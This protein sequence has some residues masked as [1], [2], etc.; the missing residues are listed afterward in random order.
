MAGVVAIVVVLVVACALAYERV[1]LR[2]I[3]CLHL[4]E[5]AVAV[6]R[7]KD[8][9]RQ[10]WNV[11]EF[12]AAVPEMTCNNVGW[13]GVG[14]DGVEVTWECTI[15]D[16]VPA[17][18]AGGTVKCEGWDYPDDPFVVAGSCR[19][20]YTLKPFPAPAPPARAAGLIGT[21]GYWIDN[22][23]Q[24]L[25]CGLAFV[26]LA[27]V[28][29]LTFPAALLYVIGSSLVVT[30]RDI[31]PDYWI[32]TLVVQ[33]LAGSLVLVLAGVF[34]LIIS[35]VSLY[36]EPA[37]MQRAGRVFM[38]TMDRAGASASALPAAEAEPEEKWEWQPSPRPR[39][40]SPPPTA[41]GAVQSARAALAA[42]ARPCKRQ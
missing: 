27:W 7:S 10:L 2:D 30:L 3:T 16:D 21:L 11:G 38:D 13:D 20:L 39:S 32:D 29:A 9:P 41:A 26:A 34:V 17:K 8:V 22:L 25:T 5:G 24:A 42:M 4:A 1:H 36:V 33:A 23:V 19:V 40:C 14:W 28:L 37:C 15:P 35:A 12:D 6:T 18:L 31:T